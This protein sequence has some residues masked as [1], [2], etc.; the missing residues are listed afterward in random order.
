MTQLINELSWSHS[1]RNTLM[2]AGESV[3]SLLWLLGGWSWNATKAKGTL[4]SQKA[5]QQMDVDGHVVHNAVEY[6][7]DVVKE[8]SLRL[9]ITTLIRLQDG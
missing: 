6:L 4:P 9:W 7:L 8:K 2:N 5:G 3:L 1:R